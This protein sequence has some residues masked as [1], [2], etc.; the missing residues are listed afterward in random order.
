M[1]WGGT[2]ETYNIFRWY[3]GGWGRYT[4][5][6]PVG[7]GGP[8]LFRDGK[9]RRWPQLYNLTPMMDRDVEAITSRE[10]NQYAYVSD[11]PLAFTDPLGLEKVACAVKS[12]WPQPVNGHCIYG[13]VALAFK[14]ARSM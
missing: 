8:G 13:G 3:R 14:R 9:W 2:E 6:D 10:M 7:I 1:T 12:L 4:Q 11:N 5:A